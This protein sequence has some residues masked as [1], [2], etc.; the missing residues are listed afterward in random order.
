[1]SLNR[2]AQ[3]SL[4]GILL[5]E[6]AIASVLAMQCW[7]AAMAVGRTDEPNSSIPRIELLWSVSWTPDPETLLLLVVALFGALGASVHALTSLA[8]YYGNKT[9]STRWAWW[10]LIRLPV[11]M[12]I[13]LLFYLL[14]R[15]GLLSTDATASVVNPYATAGLAGLSGMFSKQATDKL[16]ELFMTLFRTAEG[17][18]R[19]RH[20]KVTEPSDDGLT[21][22]A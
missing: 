9:F 4:P 1:M 16:E 5:A 22:A 13:A 21:E 6:A 10:Y 11:G 18:D 12:L 19:R 14:L 15:G 3:R 7:P 17:G 2:I 8:T 20:D